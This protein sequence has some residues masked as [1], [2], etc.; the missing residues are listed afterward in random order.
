MAIKRRE[1]DINT[2]RRLL[3]MVD[4]KDSY[5]DMFLTDRVSGHIPQLSFNL[6]SNL[7]LNARTL[8]Y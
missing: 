4:D 5:L 3:R 6:T 8:P 2:R 7:T 1:Q